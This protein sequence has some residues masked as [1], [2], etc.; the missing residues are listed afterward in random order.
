MRRF[1]H[2][3]LEIFAFFLLKNLVK[4]S[5]FIY[6]FSFVQNSQVMPNISEKHISKK[7]PSAFSAVSFCDSVQISK[8][9]IPIPDAWI[10]VC[11]V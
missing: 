5:E 3:K 9:S 11:N 7:V 10:S 1:F 8:T 4:M 2:I 6:Y